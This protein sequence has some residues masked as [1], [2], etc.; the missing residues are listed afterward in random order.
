MRLSADQG[1]V[2]YKQALELGIDLACVL[3]TCDGDSFRFVI[4]VDT[5]L[6]FM[7]MVRLDDRGAP[8]QAGDAFARR[9]VRGRVEVRLLARP[10][11]SW[12]HECAPAPEKPVRVARSAVSRR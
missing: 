3:L 11:G 6:G 12:P 8:V 7:S 1:D 9:V 10:D 5:D 2:G 4:T